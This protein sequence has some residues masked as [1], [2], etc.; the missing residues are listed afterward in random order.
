MKKFTKYMAVS[1]LVLSA[2]SACQDDFDN[3]SPKV[4]VA[5][6]EANTTIAELKEAFWADS[7]NYSHPVGVREDGSH[8]IVK[9]RVISSDNAGNIYRAFYFADE[10]ASLCV[11]LSGYDLW[12]TYRPGQEIVIDATGLWLGKYRGLQQLGAPKWE[13]DRQQTTSSFMSTALFT[14]HVQFSGMPDVAAIDTLVL[15]EKPASAKEDQIRWQG[16]LVRFNNVAFAANADGIET[17]CDEFQS[18]G[19]TQKIDLPNS[20]GTIDVRTSGYCDF[21][22]MKVPSGSGD[23][24]GILSYYNSG[25]SGDW[26]LMLIDPEGLMNFGN[27][28]VE[29]DKE[30]PYTVRQAISFASSGRTE[31]GWVEGYIVGT[32]APE[33]TEVTKNEDIQFSAPFIMANTLVIADSPDCRDFAECLLVSLPE[34]SLLESAGNLVDNPELLGRKMG[35]DGRFATDLGMAAV[36][37][38]AGKASEFFIEGVE[39][40]EDPSGAIAD[41]DGSQASPY[42]PAQVLKL[43]N[44]GTTAWVKGYI[45]GSAADKTADSFTTATGAAASGT[46]IFIAATPDETD[47][48]NCIPVQL[49]AGEIRNALNLQANPGNLGKVVTLNGSLEKYFGLPGVKTVTAYELGGQGSGGDEPVTPPAGDGIASGDGSES[50]PYNPTQVLGLDNPGTISWVKGYIVGSAA[51]K[52]AD[53]FTTATGAAASGNNIFIATTPDETDYTKCVPVQLPAGDVRTGLNL[54]ANPGNL[55]KVVTLTGSLEKYFGL[56][57][58]KSVTAFSLDG[59]GSGGGDEPVNPG[60]TVGDGSASSP[61]TVADLFL[62]NNPATTGWATGYIVGS[63]AGKSADTFTTATGAEA[64]G[65]NVFIAASASE[66]DY[67]KCIPVQLPAG[68]VRDALNLQANPGNLGKQ[69][70]LFGSFEKYFGM[71]G[72][73]TVTE[74]NLDGGQGGGDD[75]PVT[76]PAGGTEDQ[77]YTVEQLIALGN[78]GATVWTEG[79]IIGFVN[80][81]SYAG[82][83]LGADS[84]LAS[85]VII[86]ASADETDFAKC[87]PV[88]LPAGDVR[89]AINLQDNPGNLGRKLKLQGTASAYCGT[90]GL[91]AVSAYSFE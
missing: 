22:N 40:P 55:G 8:Y 34:G 9:G 82:A 27:P 64:S 71:V 23:V 6:L 73:K 88:Q 75:E 56:P 79:Y 3:E 89:A 90:P 47:Y 10:T 11:S 52:T 50:A 54:Q 32:V 85:N 17:L 37:G 53:S 7:L 72:I 81:S 68:A 4:P 24:V 65:T 91:R 87:V 80:G 19:Y 67:T 26:Q 36:K 48:N 30:H 70:A 31:N 86:A 63:A 76:P 39:L 38:Y 45:V 12:L 16:Q 1:A 44:P 78:N 60:A 18:S 74:F 13:F 41:G 15:K 2:L 5:T 33:V 42:S 49:P 46:N 28:T 69:V 61:Y 29:G 66:T 57:G 83:T 58:V 21:W 20:G 77:P 35:I 43:G 14:P 51:D 59:E 25:S 62:L 84:A